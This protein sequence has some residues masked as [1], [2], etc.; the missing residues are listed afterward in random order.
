MS[1]ANIMAV[2]IGAAGLLLGTVL[3]NVAKKNN[4]PGFV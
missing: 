2:C 3:A 1:K 4:V